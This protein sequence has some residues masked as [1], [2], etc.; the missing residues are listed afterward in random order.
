MPL[1][2]PRLSGLSALAIML[3]G[4]FG[5]AQATP[6]G[7]QAL[8]PGEIRDRVA[9]I[10][11]AAVRQYRDLLSLPND[12]HR[13][14]DI[15]RLVRWLEGA[16]SERNFQVQRLETP[17]SP[18]LLAQRRSPEASAPTVLIYLQSDGQPVDPTEWFQDDPYGPVLKERDPA[19]PSR[20]GWRSIPWDTLDAAGDPARWNPEWRVF[21]RSASDSKGPIAQFL[22]ALDVVDGAGVRQGFH[23]KVIVDTEEEMGSPH[24]PR[25]V[26]TYRDELASDMLLI[27][28]GPPHVSGRPSLK[29]G[30][31]GIADVTLTTYGPRVPQHSGHYGNYTPNPALRMAQLLA[32]MKDRDGRVVIPGFYDGVDIDMETARILEAVPDDEEEIRRRLG[33]AESDRVGGSLQEAVQYPSL[34]VRGLSSAWVGDEARTIVPATATAEIDVRLV[35]ES[36][37]DRLL[38]LIRDHIRNQ[39][40]LVLDRE[41]TEEERLAHPRI[42]T[43]VSSVSYLAFRTDF[44]SVPGIWTRNALTHLFGEAPILI[45]TSGGSVPISP[46]VTTLGIPA[47]S[48]PTV[49]PDNNQHSPNENLRLGSFLEGIEIL[50]AV[51]AQ[52]LPTS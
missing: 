45:R 23:M 32:S 29:F 36:D 44:D 31:R 6:A 52:P 18:L 34:N 11:P 3:S 33:I 40:Y 43:M 17:G 16:F 21:A 25:A 22:A 9:G 38:G 39:D 28:D 19:D 2:R 13:P 7:A 20:G 46:F 47:V 24:L 5:L 50:T 8:S 41:P 26:S 37:P 4:M 1:L 35:L 51:L 14:D 48:V 27:F 30:A 42:V 12:A 10:A 49:N 15:E